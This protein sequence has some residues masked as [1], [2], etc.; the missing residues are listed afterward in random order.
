MCP[1]LNKTITY[2]PYLLTLFVL[3]QYWHVTNGQTDIIVR[4]MYTCRAVKKTGLYYVASWRRR[5]ERSAGGYVTPYEFRS[6]WSWPRTSPTSSKLHEQLTKVPSR[7]LTCTVLKG[8]WRLF[9][10]ISF[11]WLRVLDKAEYSA[12]ES[13]LH[14]SIVLY[15][16]VSWQVRLTVWR[17]QTL[18]PVWW[19][20]DQQTPLLGLTSA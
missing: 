14:S 8:H 16:M 4:T 1:F 20:S 15:R 9:V 5:F 13:T 3:R 7:I 12:F 19:E 17:R 11:F 6:S 2:L 18:S 10:L